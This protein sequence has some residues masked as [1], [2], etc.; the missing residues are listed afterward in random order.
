MPKEH[1]NRRRSTIANFVVE[2]SKTE[3]TPS[4]D[5]VDEDD[6]AYKTTAAKLRAELAG[7]QAKAR[8]RR[9]SIVTGKGVGGD[10]VNPPSRMKHARLNSA[11]LAAAAPIPPTPMCPLTPPTP[12]PTAVAAVA[13]HSSSTPPLRDVVPESREPERQFGPE[14]DPSRVEEKT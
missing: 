11:L 12:H 13:A 9:V 14:L 2:N 3:F 10:S 7:Q 4:K 1:L 6:K 5:T 8:Q